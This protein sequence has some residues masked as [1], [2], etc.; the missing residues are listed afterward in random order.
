MTLALDPV[1]AALYT[2]L[3]VVAVT[4]LAPGGV[5][6]DPAQG[7]AFP[8]VWLEL[9]ERQVGGLGVTYLPEIELRVHIFSNSTLQVAHQVGS[10]VLTLLKDAAALTVTGFTQ[11]GRVVYEDTMPLTDQLLNG[12]KVHELVLRF[13]IWVEA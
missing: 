6:D 7:T 8:F 5:S 9:N 3:N 4:N 10:A 2:V 1:T 11:A 12:V 13:R